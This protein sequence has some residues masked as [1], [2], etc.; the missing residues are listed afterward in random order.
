MAKRLGRKV[1]IS[2]GGSVVA[3]ARTKTLTI[4]N[5]PVNVTADG[6]DGIQKMLNEPGEKSVETS[7][8]GLGDQESFIT[9][10]LSDDLIEE[11]VLNYGT[12][13]ITGDFFQ[14]SY[15]EGLPYN[16][17]ITFTASYQSSGAVVKAAV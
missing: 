9:K 7:I 3:V 10:A 13:T 15:S 14:A 11:V 17:S 1:T 12:F 4:N 5:E 16:D 8:D 2:V 6:D